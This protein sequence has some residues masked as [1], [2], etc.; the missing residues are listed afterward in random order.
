MDDLLAIEHQLAND[1]GDAYRR[2]LLDD[3]VVIVPGM[4]LDK[5]ETAEA[6][7]QSPGWDEWSIEEPRVVELTPDSRI[8]TYLWRSRQG[9]E[10]YTAFMSSTYVRR[11]GEWKLAMHQQTL[12]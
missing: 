6:I 2:H 4:V 5:E 10:R 7:D 1:G 3:A 11:D 9:D 12:N 8:L